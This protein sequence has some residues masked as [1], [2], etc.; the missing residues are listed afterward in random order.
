[1]RRP[2]LVSLALAALVLAAA[3]AP[4]Q[5][6]ATAETE[7][8]VPALGAFHE[9]IYPLWHTAWPAKDVNL[10][11]ELLPQVKE[12]VAALQKAELSGI[13]RDKKP[14]WDEGV[15]NVV[16]ATQAYDQ[17]LAQN[18]V[19]ELLDAVEKLHA[20]FERLAR[21]IRPAMPELE[22]YHQVLYQ[23]Y[24]HDWPDRKLDALRADS[25]A[26][27]GSCDKLVRATIPSRYATRQAEL[28]AGMARL[29]TASSA[30]RTSLQE[31]RGDAAGPAVERVH[32]AYQ[33]LEKLFQ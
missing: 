22:A 9:V 17:A 6:H 30:L 24:H 32:Q 15:K 31:G 7:A 14:K 23:I 16:A 10:I 26:L 18:K 28:G 8:E 4:A 21:L 13:L 29:C 1:M 27:V 19:P 25:E 33:E 3:P 20:G 5:S 11:R 12:H 2:S